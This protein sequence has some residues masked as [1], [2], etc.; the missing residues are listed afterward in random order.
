VGRCSRWRCRGLARS[1]AEFT[2]PG[3]L[4]APAER[5]SA[6]RELDVVPQIAGGVAPILL[7]AS[8]PAVEFDTVIAA[9]GTLNVLPR[10]QRIKMG[11]SRGGQHANVWADENSVH[12]VIDGQLVKTVP[13]NLTPTTCTN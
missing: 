6:E 7:P 3:C 4:G 10:A 13:S 9:G 11:P 12:I 1:S 2:Q 8:A 5:S